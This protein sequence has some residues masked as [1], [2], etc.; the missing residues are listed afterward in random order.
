MRIARHTQGFTVIE[1]LVGMMITSII[2]AAVATLA[3][4]LTTASTASSDTAAAQTRLRQATLRIRDLVGTC[5][6][7]C[8]APGT[9]LVLWTADHN[10]DNRID[11]NEIVYIER[12]DPNSALKLRDFNLKN[13]PTVLQALGLSDDTDPVLTTLAQPETKAA[14]V[15]VYDPLHQVRRITLLQGC[16]NVTLAWDRDPPRTRRLTISFDLADNGVHRYEIDA[17]RRASAEYLLSAD[18]RT[19]VSDD[20]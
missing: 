17:A 20:D 10:H 4:A 1:L 14:L 5:K 18:E 9:D 16:S 19:L 8:A 12:D 3:Y 2:L 11:V 7:L 15:G 13:S 6:L